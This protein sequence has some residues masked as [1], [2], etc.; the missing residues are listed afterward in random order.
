MIAGFGFGLNSPALAA[1]VVGSISRA[2]LALGSAIHIVVKTTGMMIGLAALGGWGI[3]TFES[4]LDL[5]GLPL[6]QRQQSFADQMARMRAVIEQRSMDAILVVLHR[7]FIVAAVMC[8]L[9]II[10]SLLIRVQC[11][12]GGCRKRRQQ[13][14]S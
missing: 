5:E 10:P 14:S 13:R 7:F 12:R 8:A 9:A 4:S 3:Y 1:A 6:L 2:R 11:R